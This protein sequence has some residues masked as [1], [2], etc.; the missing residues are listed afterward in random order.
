MRTLDM[1]QLQ[2]TLFYVSMIGGFGDDDGFDS[3]FIYSLF[4]TARDQLWH[5][6]RANL[7]KTKQELNL[8]YS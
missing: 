4:N 8:E 1:L 5:Y 7:S 2:G 3:L 6:R